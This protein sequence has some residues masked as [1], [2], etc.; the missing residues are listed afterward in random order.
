MVEQVRQL[1]ERE[2]NI[3]SDMLEQVIKYRVE[4]KRREQVEIDKNLVEEEGAKIEKVCQKKEK[5]AKCKTKKTT[6]HTK[7]IKK[8][9]PKSYAALV[10][11]VSKTPLTPMG[12]LAPGSAH[13]SAE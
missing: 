9:P 6:T 11:E 8:G 3:L 7:I 13:V 12:V 5:R 2:E 4:Q 1:L 10:R